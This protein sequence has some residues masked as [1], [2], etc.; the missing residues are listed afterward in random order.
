MRTNLFIKISSF[1]SSNLSL[2]VYIHT[3]TLLSISNR[4]GA[5]LLA[6][7]GHQMALLKHIK[8]VWGNFTC[9]VSFICLISSFS[10]LWKCVICSLF[11]CYRIMKES[12]LMHSSSKHTCI[13]S[14]SNRY[15]VIYKVIESSTDQLRNA[16]D[17]HIIMVSIYIEVKVK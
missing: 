6:R 2:Y 14:I 17:L 10:A 4:I 5:C 16:I 1:T 12:H 9:L 11:K 8:H 3:Y 13:D 15:Q 7:T